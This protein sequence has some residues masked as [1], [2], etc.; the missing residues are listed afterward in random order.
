MHDPQPMQGG[1]ARRPRRAHAPRRAPQA[2]PHADVGEP[3]QRGGDI[4]AQPHLVAHMHVAVQPDGMALLHHP[5]DQRR[6]TRGARCDR[7]ERRASLGDRE[8]VEQPRR[9]HRI[10]TV[11]EG[12]REH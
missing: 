2:R 10:G 8:R 11:V 6:M 12:E 3:R 1:D 4:A 9:P 5:P 7:K